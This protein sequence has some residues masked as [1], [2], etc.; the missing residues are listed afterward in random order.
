MMDVQTMDQIVQKLGLFSFWCIKTIHS[1]GGR[2][3]ECQIRADE[4]GFDNRK[5]YNAT[6]ST[7]HDACRAAIAKALGQ[8]PAKSKHVP[9]LRITT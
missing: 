8:V 9:S 7:P 4:H 6:R 2:R 1:K 3:Y 5:C